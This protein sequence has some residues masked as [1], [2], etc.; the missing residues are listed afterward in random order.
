[1]EE[2]LYHL[3]KA[4][5]L[6]HSH[7]IPIDDEEMESHIAHMSEEID[8]LR[9]FANR[10]KDDYFIDPD[11]LFDPKIDHSL[12]ATGEYIT[13]SD[14]TN[15]LECIKAN[16]GSTHYIKLTKDFEVDRSWLEQEGLIDSEE[17][18]ERY[19]SVFPPETGFDFIQDAVDE[20][21]YYNID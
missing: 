15:W 8:R 19:E 16:D 2:S 3:I 17:A 7:S 9:D 13:K 14:G 12:E 4:R 6:L 1:M 11:D 21:W 20:G 18:D 10:Y 5:D